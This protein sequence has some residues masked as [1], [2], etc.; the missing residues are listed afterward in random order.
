MPHTDKIRQFLDA[1]IPKLHGRMSIKTRLG[2]EHKKE[3][4]ALIP[5]FNEYPIKE[6]IIHPRTGKQMYEGEP[7]LEAF[8]TAL[9]M[10]RHP[11]VYNGDIRTADGFN[12]LS[13]RFRKLTVG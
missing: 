11:V 3:L 12:R 7:D 10:C 5:V 13:Q 9:S 6:L 1:T 2:R 8:E 4:F